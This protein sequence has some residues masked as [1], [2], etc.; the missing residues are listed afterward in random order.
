[1]T[2]RT[3]NANSTVRRA[4]ARPYGILCI[5]VAQFVVALTLTPQ[6]VRAQSAGFDVIETTIAQ[7]HTAMREGRLTAR[8]LVQLYLDR[9]EAYDR[10]GPSFNA[11]TRTHPR[12]LEIADSL[13]RIFAQTGQFAGALHGIPVIVKENYDT[14][15]L[16]TT[17]GAR[18][19]ANSIPPDDAFMVNRVRAAGGIVFARS[20]MA[21]WAFSPLETIGSALPGY[22]FNPYA[23]NRVP[24]GS[25]GG[26]AAAVAANLGAVGL[27]TDTGNSIRGPSSHAALVGIRSTIGLTSRDGIIP[28][29]LER[30]VGGPMTRTVED[31]A[32]MLDV[33]AGQDP[34]DPATA[35][36]AGH[37]PPTY[38]S[39][40]DRNALRGAR[41]GV[42]RRLSNRNGA[43]PEV[44][45]RFEEAIAELRRQGATVVDSIDMWVLDSVRVTLCSSFKRDLE[46]YLAT[47][48]A[49]AP[50][51]TV[52]DILGT[53]NGFHPSVE[54]RLRGSLN[55][56][57]AGD[58]QR[59]RRAQET[60]QAFQAGLRSIMATH[61]LDALIYPTWAN[62]ARLVGDLTT[63][64]G[65]NSQELSPR[66]NF[67]AIT[68]PMGWVLDN[69]VPVGLQILGDAWSEGRLFALAF[70]YEQ[71]THHRRPPA[72]AP[73]LVATG[74][75]R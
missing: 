35:A 73:A 13:D 55:D 70:A 49:N 10:R 75:L 16:P 2:D 61:R 30:D 72:S 37:I 68:V 18:V 1:M 9:I 12:A 20:N 39:F 74:R 22:T 44:I 3:R 8:H 45:A 14:Y 66:S 38:T 48:G 5:S 51:R 15:D 11:L 31:A 60:K 21:E 63:P 34:A 59:C 19:L 6:S 17:A 25:S 69:S 52:E 43:H 4:H 28:L 41:L 64:A 54:Q 33:L 50:V 42:V 56:S 57:T 29:Y 71:A 65:D 46:A 26:T 53:R 23:L 36:S 27:G 32:R 47:L 7:I 58:P 62:P 40:L 24:A 67:P